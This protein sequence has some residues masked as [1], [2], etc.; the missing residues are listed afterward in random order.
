MIGYDIIF[1]SVS[2]IMLVSAFLALRLR[3]IMN[4][5]EAFILS[6]SLVAVLFLLLEHP[7]LSFIQLAI[8]AGGVG[9]IILIAIAL[10]KPSEKREKMKKP[11]SINQKALIPGLF[12]S[13]LFVGTMVYIFMND[14]SI[15]KVD[16]P[17]LVFSDIVN[18]LLTNYQIPLLLIAMTIFAV[19]VGATKILRSDVENDNNN[20]EEVVSK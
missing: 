20:Y 9:V 10:M 7:Y 17:A 12:I 14:P 6:I 5:A 11:A 18:A 4:A 1:Y 2:A 3:N 8:Y 13:I 16:I 19:I 15:H